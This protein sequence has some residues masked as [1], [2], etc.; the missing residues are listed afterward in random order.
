MGS[1]FSRKKSIRTIFF[2]IGGVIVKAP[3][4]E[5]LKYGSEIFECEPRHLEDATAQVLPYL[6]TGEI[7]TDEFW[8]KIGSA[9]AAS[10]TGKAAPVWRFKGFWEGILSDSLSVDTEMINLVRRL[11][12]HVRVAALTNVI[13]EH[14]MLLQRHN[15]YEHFNPVVLS[16][17]IGLRKPDPR[18][19]EKAAELAK[20][21]PERCLLIDD[22]LVNLE[23]AQKF[24]YRVL[25]YTNIDDLKRALYQL[26][27]LD[28]V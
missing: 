11:K 14:A 21:S 26:G 5:F 7:Q 28:S 18:I 9:L 23:A 6:E 10:G 16:C 15:V 25:Q 27:F 19:Y 22:S 24:G 12:A 2:D 13:K 8:E 3:T 17:K 4:L 20:T 1:L